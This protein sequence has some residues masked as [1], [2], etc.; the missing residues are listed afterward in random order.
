MIRVVLLDRDGVINVSPPDQGYVCSPGELHLVEGSPEAIAKL[1]RAGIKVGVVSNQAG[2]ERGIL[3]EEDLARVTERLHEEL[4]Q[5]GAHLDALEY[6][7]VYDDSDP[8]RK[9]NP[10]MLLEVMERLGAE[11]CEAVMVGDSL[12]D[13]RA[14]K[15]AG[16][17]TVLVLTGEVR[18]EKQIGDWDD[19]PDAV[20]RSLSQFVDELLEGTCAF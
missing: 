5:A 11:A 7:K 4:G 17:R 6:C 16:C 3:S 2:V 9:P 13:I 18:S 19:P 20:C 14:G 10:G 1:N 12:R 8:R 15:S